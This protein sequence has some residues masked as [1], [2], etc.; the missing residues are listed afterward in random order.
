MTPEL[1]ADIKA[2]EAYDK[3]LSQ[4]DKRMKSLRERKAKLEGV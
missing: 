4:I 3:R 2:V 1:K